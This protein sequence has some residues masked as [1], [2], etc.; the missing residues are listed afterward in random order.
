MF[1]LHFFNRTTFEDILTKSEQRDYDRFGDTVRF[2]W[3]LMVCLD[4]VGFREDDCAKPQWKEILDL[5]I[6]Y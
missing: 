6:K 1:V 4:E 3:N 5:G 2:H